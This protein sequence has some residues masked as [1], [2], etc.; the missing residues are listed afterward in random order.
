MMNT[1][2][3]PIHRKL[4]IIYGLLM[5]ALVAVTALTWA[6]LDRVG[7]TAERVA[8]RY[9]PQLDLISDVQM[10]MFRISLEARHAMLVET[11]EQREATFQ[12]IGQNRQQMLDKLE[13]FEANLSTPEGRASLARIREADTL[14]WRL[15]GEV[16]GKIQAGDVKAAFAQLER[17][18]VPARDAMVGH[19]AE[20]RIWQQK[21]VLDAVSGAQADAARNRQIVLALAVAPSLLAAWLAWTLARMMSGAFARAH[22][23]TQRIAGGHLGQEV[24]VRK[25]D[26]FGHLFGSIADM[27]ERLLHV[28][29]N[30]RTVADQIG[31]AAQ[32]IDEANRE[33]EQA[34]ASHSQSVQDTSHSARRMTDAVRD[35]A[36]SVQSVHRLASEAAQVAAAGGAVVGDVV[37]TMRGIDESS[38]RIAEIVSVIDGIAFQTNILALNA[39]VEAARAGEQGRGFAVVAGEV[40]ALAQRSASAAREVK[41]LIAESV[42]RVGS[43]TALAD[44]AGQTMQRIVGS[45]TEVTQLI[46]GVAQSTQAQSADVDAVTGAVDHIGTANAKSVSAVSR[47]TAASAALREHALAL[48]AAVAAFNLH[49]A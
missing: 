46:N 16:V 35:S 48:Q 32:A 31:V 40:R 27:Q 21:L 17:D 12:R 13:R 28:V 19:I 26:E 42:E 11:P 47:S 43:G 49:A 41:T 15:G 6:A 36:H 25:G 38:K 2:R 44:Q 5:A 22:V 30:V 29:T 1:A 37:Q 33:L 10:L 24:Y 3:I 4:A 14:F 18:L 9:A 45:V 23:V 39:A 20:Q 7:S 34:S 8:T